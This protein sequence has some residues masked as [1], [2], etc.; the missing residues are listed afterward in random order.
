MPASP[1]QESPAAALPTLSLAHKIIGLFGVAL[2]AL[3]LVLVITVRSAQATARRESLIRDG[4]YPLVEGTRN[5]EETMVALERRYEEAP[6]AHSRLRLREARQLAAQFDHDRAALRANA[7]AN[8]VMFDSIGGLVAAYAAIAD[9]TADSLLAGDHSPHVRADSDAAATRYTDIRRTLGDLDQQNVAAA[10]TAFAIA[11]RLQRRSTR[12][13]IGVAIAAALTLA[14]LAGLATRALTGPLRDVVRM[15]DRI[16]Q[17]D[18]AVTIEAGRPDELGKLRRSMHDLV[19]YLHTMADHADAIARGDLT[20]HV[21]PRADSDRFGHAFAGMT[22]ALREMT[23]VATAIADGDL[24]VRLTPRSTEDQLGLAFDR[25]VSYLASMAEVSQAIAAGDLS[26]QVRVRSERDTFGHAFRTMTETLSHA[27]ATLRGS[28]AAVAAAASQVAASANTLSTGTQDEAA[29]VERAIGSIS[30]VRDLAGSTAQHAESL[31]TM[32]ERDTESMVRGADSVESVIAGA[33][34][35]VERIAVIDDIATETNVLALNASLEA[36]RAGEHGRGFS[37]VAHAIRALSNRSR[38]AADDVR[39]MAGAGRQE[40]THTLERL[41]Q[42]RASMVTTARI[43]GEV[44]VAAGRQS[45]GIVNIDDAMRQLGGVTTTNRAAA[46]DLAATA[47]EL[48]AQA[49]EL[50]QLVAFFRRTDGAN[51]NGAAVPDALRIGT[52]AG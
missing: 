3:V 39:R 23:A 26:A 45:T 15:A 37:V 47:Q 9:S 46:Q 20:R 34:S 28:A 40:S 35:I 16:A 2:I 48:S 6:L 44:A 17:G 38:D 1:R 43:V 21:E 32:A 22:V 19:T 31:R 18:L 8:R 52:Q 24:T 4:Y 51:G 10:D 30:L 13:L 25:M 42:Q 12:T 29:V 27:A 50:E 33:A 11:E 49:A 36:A 41:Q 7:V 5:L 14:G